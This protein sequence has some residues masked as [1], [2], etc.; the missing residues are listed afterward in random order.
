[1][2]RPLLVVAFSAGALLSTLAIAK[3]MTPVPS[4]EP[5][6]PT[7]APAKVEPKVEPKKISPA[8][9]TGL[10]A[11]TVKDID[12][13]DVNL[14]EA[15]KGK[16]VL[17]VNVASQC[18]YTGQYSG[19]QE[20][21]TSRKDK[22]LV[23]LGFPANNFGGQ[24]PGSESEIKQF[25]SSNYSVTFP[26]FS[27]VSA[28]GSDACPL[29]KALAEDPKGGSPKWNF[30]KYLIDRSGNLVAK[31]DSGTKPMGSELTTKID[32]LLAAKVEAKP[33]SKPDAKAPAEAKPASGTPA[34][35]T[36]PADGKPAGDAPA[37]PAKGK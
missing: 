4:A 31:Y 3:P 35:P 11:Q 8:A 37:A 18:G 34:A 22:G 14:A 9:A 16:V 29:F 33:E 27:K 30:T 32:E 12:G 1:M 7:P 5:K 17:I 36:K 25:C 21:Y 28:K 24:E 2:A 13:K 15:Y 26:M 20:L 10:L 6:T 23:I 19:L